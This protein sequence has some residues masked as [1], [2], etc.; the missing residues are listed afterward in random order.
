MKRLILSFV[1][2]LGILLLIPAASFASA[3]ITIVTGNVTYNGNGVSGAKVTVVCD[4]NAKK[5]TTDS[6]GAYQVK[7]TYAKCPDSSKAT[8]VATDGSKGGVNS[9]KVN[10]DGSADLNVAIVNVNL[11]EL[12]VYTGGGAAILGGAAFIAIRRKELNKS[13]KTEK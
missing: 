6:T 8:V 9:G 13:A 10:Q 7:Y 4:N 1:A 2:S 12:T 3:A 11:P 5:T